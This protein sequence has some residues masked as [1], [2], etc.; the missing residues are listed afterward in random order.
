MTPQDALDA[1]VL[2]Q[3]TQPAEWVQQMHEHYRRAGYYRPQDLERVL[4][5]PRQ[6]F[7]G[8]ASDNL[9]AASKIAGL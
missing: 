3:T 7:E 4:G 6:K 1:M 9:L 8:K 5:D 2:T